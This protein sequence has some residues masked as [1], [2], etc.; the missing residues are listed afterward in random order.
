MLA[1]LS[2]SVYINA[3]ALHIWPPLALMLEA[4]QSSV[5]ARVKGAVRAPLPV[6]HGLVSRRARS[7]IDRLVHNNYI[8]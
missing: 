5:R 4:L 6:C 7:A 3:H 8:I 1:D 2:T